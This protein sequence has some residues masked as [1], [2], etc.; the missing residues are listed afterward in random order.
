MTRRP[1]IAA[2]AAALLAASPVWA[3]VGQGDIEAGVTVSLTSSEQE[4]DTGAG[5]QT[6]KTDYG[7][8]NLS[9]A[10]FYTDN[11]Q[12]KVALSLFVSTDFT[13]GT[14]NPGADYLFAVGRTGNVVPFAGASFGLGVADSETD[15]LEGHGG[16]KYFFRENASVE[17]SLGYS[18][19]TDSAYDA[20]TDL[21]VGLN[22]YF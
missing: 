13:A 10:Y 8:V 4:I 3:D 7:I 22:V 17:A 16:V 15:Y 2:A 18:M 1:W 20:T 21:A 12:I 6:T 19:P 5:T 11:L 14:L 9:G